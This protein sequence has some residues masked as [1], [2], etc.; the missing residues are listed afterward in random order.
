M[1]DLSELNWNEGAEAV[2]ALLPRLTVLRGVLETEPIRELTRCCASILE[3]DIRMAAEACFAMT[4]A[5]LSGGYRRVTG[6]LF[7]DMLLHELLLTPHPFAKMAAANRLD[8]ALYSG[9]KEDM[10]ILATLSGLDGETLYRFIQERYKELKQKL[11]PSKDPAA[12]L[13]EAAW[14]GSAVRPV[15]EEEPR[16]IP[17]LPAFLPGGAPNW[18]YGE[19]ELRDSYAADEALEEMYHR[20]LESG[21][22]WQTM[23]EDVWNFFAAYGTGDF[24]KHRMFVWRRGRLQPMEDARLA[25]SGPLLETEYRSALNHLIEFMR[26]NGAEP[27]LIQGAQGMGK[28]TM[29]FSLAD[30]LPE[31]RFVYAPDIASFAELTP[32]FEILAAQ[33]LKFMVALDDAR[34]Q[35]FALRAVP[36]NVLPAAASS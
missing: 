21:L 3:G 16:P 35:G 31:L 7:K 1:R 25:S 12:R 26:D 15:P 29:L 32:L 2:L 11:R 22:E 20:F 13:A 6:H 33:P 23:A 4:G 9:I 19:E 30:E 18:L 27:M 28:T 10:E 8:E 14:G 36:V 34:M 17:S 24:L 5:L